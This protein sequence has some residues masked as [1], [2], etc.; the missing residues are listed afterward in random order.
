[1]T[2]REPRRVLVLG[3]SGMLGHRLIAT[4][5][6]EHHVIAGFRDDRPWRD[7]PLFRHERVTLRSG[8]DAGQFDTVVRA[9]ESSRPDVIVNAVG[10]IKQ[11]DA[12]HDPLQSI[13]V[14]S[15]L[16]HRLQRLAAATGA[17]LVHFSTDC[18]FSGRRGGYV[19]D[20]TPDP[21]DLYGRSK[22]LG[23]VAAENTVTLRT[24]IIGRELRRSTGLLEW[25]LSKRGSRVSGYRR[26]VYSGLTTREAARVV[27]RLLRSH[28]D[29]SGVIHVASEPI[30]KFDLL[31]K[32]RD[33]LG[34]AI[35]IDPVDEPVSDRSLR[36]G[37]FRSLTGYVAPSWDAMI[38]AL[39]PDVGE[40][41]DWRSQHVVV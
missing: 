18:V 8:I 14:N 4:L 22:L 34:L 12:A 32:L 15:L 2:D 41:D 40:Y 30:T 29:V 11:I 24:S 37:K 5:C 36:A 6:L 39:M 7:C 35:D 21:V 19:E 20:D 31:T 1:M 27:A 28:G 26:V 23:E 9:I 13:E 25:L 3:A 16:P 33:T 10:I 38:A 17:R